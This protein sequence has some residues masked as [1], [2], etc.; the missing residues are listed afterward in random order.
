MPVVSETFNVVVRR[1][2]SRLYMFRKL[3]IES[4][5]PQVVAQLKAFILVRHDHSYATCF[6]DPGRPGSDVQRNVATFGQGFDHSPSP[7]DVLM[8]TQSQQV[9]LRSRSSQNAART[10]GR[11]N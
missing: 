3:F 6:L 10:I 7:N 1:L 2:A 4:L 11:D 9:T 8:L 5:D